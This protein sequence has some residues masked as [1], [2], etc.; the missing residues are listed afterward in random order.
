ML[1]IDCETPRIADSRWPTHWL[2]GCELSAEMPLDDYIMAL[3]EGKAVDASAESFATS[4]TERVVESRQQLE[5]S[6]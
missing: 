6:R 2:V 5:R 1:N 3:E 4:H